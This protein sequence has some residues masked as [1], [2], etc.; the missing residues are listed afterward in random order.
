MGPA[1][2]CRREKYGKRYIKKLSFGK[3][4]KFCASDG[5]DSWICGTD[6][7]RRKL[8]NC[9]TRE[10]TVIL[11]PTDRMVAVYDVHLAPSFGVSAH[12]EDY[13]I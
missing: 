12:T 8:R 1:I 2:T 4:I 3:G 10:G 13:G 7:E 5:N 11:I 9:A 6:A